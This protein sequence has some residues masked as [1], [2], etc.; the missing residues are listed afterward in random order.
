MQNVI[1]FSLPEN[2]VAHR[3]GPEEGHT[4]PLS[5]HLHTQHYP[6][7]NVTDI[8]QNRADWKERGAGSLILALLLSCA[9]MS[10]FLD[11]PRPPQA[12]I[13]LQDWG[14]EW[15]NTFCSK[16]VVVKT[17]AMA[18]PVTVLGTKMLSKQ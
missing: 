5:L 16:K 10:E 1:F 18:M 4:C 11:H 6:H 15:S 12:A 7:M 14:R 13:H 2:S 17:E 8:S 9:S 3:K